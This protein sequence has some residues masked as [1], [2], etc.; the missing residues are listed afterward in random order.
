MRRSAR[1]LVAGGYLVK[2]GLYILFGY[3]L[4]PEQQ[5]A[6]ATL[7]LNVKEVFWVAVIFAPLVETYLIQYLVI[8][9][10]HKWTGIYWIAVLASAII[11][12]AL[13]TYSV[14][15]MILTFL[16]GIIYGIIYVVLALRGKDPFVY[17][18]LTH[19]LHNLTGF[20]IEH[21]F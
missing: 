14:P 7:N 20:C 21:V 2:L 15:Y 1:Q 19:A 16:S 12:G 6:S 10:V 9:N 17:I 3:L 13:H 5:S 18:A 8:K 11:F 4:F